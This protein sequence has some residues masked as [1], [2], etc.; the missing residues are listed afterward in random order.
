MPTE[1]RQSIGDV[2]LEGAIPTLRANNYDISIS[3]FISVLALSLI[4]IPFFHIIP[5]LFVMAGEIATFT[6]SSSGTGMDE[7][8]KALQSAPFKVLRIVVS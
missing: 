5:N 4:N 1:E 3:K 7:Y 6:Y 2:R 8:R